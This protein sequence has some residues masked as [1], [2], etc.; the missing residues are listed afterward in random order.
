MKRRTSLLH[1][2]GFIDGSCEVCIY[3]NLW[4]QGVGV[5]LWPSCGLCTISLRAWYCSTVNLK[6]HRSLITCVGGGGATALPSHSLSAN[7]DSDQRAAQPAAIPPWA[8]FYS[9]CSQY[10]IQSWQWPSHLI[11]FNWNFG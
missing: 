7:C 8:S 5:Q 4:K 3:M 9:I 1:K 6:H 11:G 2:D 10:S